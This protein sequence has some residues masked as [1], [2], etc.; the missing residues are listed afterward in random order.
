M[1][2]TAEIIQD[3]SDRLDKLEQQNSKLT[4]DNYE[5]A[6]H[7]SELQSK[8]N[9][10]EEQLRLANQTRYGCSR[11]KVDDN[12]M[13]LFN[14]A[15][16]GV[17]AKE[18]E[19]E[20]EEINYTRN[21]PKKKS[22]ELKLEG[23]PERTVEYRLSEEEQICPC[24]EHQM[25]EMKSQESKEL[26]YV[27]AHLEVVKHVQYTYACRHCQEEEIETPVVTAPKPKSV[28]PGSVASASVIAH[29]MNQKYVEG[30]PLYRQ[31]QS[32][33]RMGIELSRQTMANWVIK[34]SQYWLEPLY[35]RM[36]EI[37]MQKDILHADE[38]EVQVLQEPDRAATSKS[39]MWLYRTGREGPPIILFDYRTT[40]ASKHPHRFLKDFGGYLHVDGYP[41]YDS[42]SWLTLSGCF[43]H[44][45]RGFDKALKVLPKDKQ[46]A[47]LPSWHGL[48]Y[49]NKLF[50]IER[51][52]VDATPQE[53]Y[54]LRL[55][56]SQPV[57]NE[58]HAWLKR[59]SKHALPNGYFA[60]AVYYCLKQWDKLTTY[61]QDGRLEIDNNRAERSI[62]PFVIG[63]K[64]WLFSNTPNGAKASA[65]TYSIME[66]VKENGLHPFRY[67]TYIFEQM[68]NMDLEAEGAIDEL[69]PFS[70]N[71]PE[72]IIVDKQ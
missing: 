20:K 66:T 56:R 47:D 39:Y 42:L 41:G 17:A 54:R 51:S 61:L 70:P 7:N 2:N 14:E 28:L 18:P 32:W 62:K 44:A 64:A 13:Q 69:L 40:R 35:N 52:L 63:R 55:E 71:L 16:Y 5:L 6:Q 12:Q 43:S 27:P 31:E 49:C 38:T 21:K 24:C 53:R 33:H 22:K 48:Q 34:A 9:W 67:L 4:Q 25:H 57:L 15:E 30:I 68:P 1:E 58:F 3:L 72:E 60:K 8:L 36:H 50:D 46:H 10:Y 65:I 23:L 59:Q 45:R 37:M 29:T 26:H 11:E 19:P